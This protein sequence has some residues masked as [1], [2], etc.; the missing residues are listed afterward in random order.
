MWTAENRARYDRRGLCYTS[1]LGD[2]GWRSSEDI[3]FM[4]HPGLLEQL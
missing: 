2:E 3:T 1:D 4:T